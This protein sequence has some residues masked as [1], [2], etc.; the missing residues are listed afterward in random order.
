MRFLEGLF[1]AASGPIVTFLAGWTGLFRGIGLSHPHWEQRATVLATSIGA[2]AALALTAIVN[3]ISVRSKKIALLCSIVLFA[4]SLFVIIAVRSK[5]MHAATASDQL[6]YS[7]T[8][9]TSYIVFLLSAVLV[10]FFAY[11]LSSGR[12]RG[13]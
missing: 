2:V 11:A 6:Y 12:R 7:G 13:R 10:V 8:W 3:R 5:T 4:A 9:E 1:Q